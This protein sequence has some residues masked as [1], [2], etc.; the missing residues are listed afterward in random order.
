M[1]ILVHQQT[2]TTTNCEKEQVPLRS[3]K[4]KV[5]RRKSS[6]DRRSSV[7]DGVV[8]SLSS[9]GCSRRARIER[10]QCF[11]P[12]PIEAAARNRFGS[13]YVDIVA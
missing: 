12:P 6:R 8:V 3:K 10:R 7:Y 1:D 5:E 11:T 2:E 9:K 4:R 13:A